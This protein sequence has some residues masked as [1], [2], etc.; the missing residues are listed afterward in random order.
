[1]EEPNP[2]LAELEP[3]RR[4]SSGRRMHVPDHRHMQG[5]HDL[6]AGGVRMLAA[7]GSAV[8]EFDDLA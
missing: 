8:F 3:V 4:L 5:A 1:M 6:A 7:A 2:F